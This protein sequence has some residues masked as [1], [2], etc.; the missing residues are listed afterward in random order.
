MSDVET[1][2]QPVAAPVMPLFFKRVVGV[3][4]A[5]HGNLKLDRSTGFAFTAAA[6][7]VPLGLR[8]SSTP[9]RSIS[10]S[11]SPQALPPRRWRCSASPKR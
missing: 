5:H 6:Q 4:P 9:P 1:A 2:P 7:S 11:C 8:P 3:N 10:R